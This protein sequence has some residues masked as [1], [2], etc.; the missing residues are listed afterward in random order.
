MSE[1]EINQGRQNF[2]FRHEGSSSSIG[3]VIPH[4][5]RVGSLF[6]EDSEI[7]GI[8]SSKHK[9]IDLLVN[10]K[11]NLSVIAMVGEGGLG[12]TTLAGKIYDNDVVKMH[13]DC[14]VWITVGKEYV[15]KDLLKTIKQQVNRQTG[16]AS[17]EIEDTEEMNEMNLMTALRKLLK[18]KC[19]MVVFDDVW[20]DDFWEDVKYALLDNN[21]GSRVMLTTRYMT[22]AHS[23]P[24]VN[25]HEL[26]HLPSDK[27]WELFCR[28]AFGFNMSCPTEL[29]KLSHEILAK[30]GGLPL[31]IVAVGGIL[32]NKN[33]VVFEW[34]KLL[35]G[36]GSKLGSDPHLRSCNRVLSEG[37][38]DLPHHLKSCLSYFALFP[39]GFKIFFGRLIRLW[40]AEGFV[41][42][43]KSYSLEQVAEDYL[44]EL[45]DRSLVQVSERKVLGRVR[46]CK[47]HDLMHEILLKKTK[48]LGFYGDLSGEDMSHKTRRISV[49][50]GTDD[51]LERIKDSKIRL[52]V[53]SM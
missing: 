10:G 8:E 1:V 5:S 31:A 20:K 51:A 50:I 41:Q 3:G 19:Y 11:S 18:G 34:Q 39:Q 24:F 25:V 29:E 17:G 49:N 45:I 33:K 12:K 30:C 44:T 13:F 9:L 47:V 2:N 36:L 42:Y 53:F 46:T 37:Y 28:K 26:E 15:K 23:A 14:Q 27:A 21:K 43:S 32:S 40:I 7:V 35:C 22:V 52:F 16:Y 6:I 4:D 48:E 38:Y